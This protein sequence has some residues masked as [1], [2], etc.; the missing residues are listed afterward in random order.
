MK[1]SVITFFLTIFISNFYLSHAEDSTTA[2]NKNFKKEK[3]LIANVQINRTSKDVTVGKVNA[4]MLLINALTGKYDILPTYKRD[5][6]ARY[7]D[8]IKIEANVQN[9]AR[10][11]GIKKLC[12]ISVNRLCNLIRA[13]IIMKLIDTVPLEV[14]SSGFASIHFKKE[15][16]DSSITDPAIFDAIRRAFAIAERDSSM[17][18]NLTV[19]LKI[20]PARTVAVGG[21]AYH[22]NENIYPSWDLFASNVISSY[23]A[24]ETITGAA[25][26]DSST[27]AVDTETRDSIYALYNLYLIENNNQPTTLEITAL[28]NLSIDYYIS[29]NFT[30]VAEGADIELY[31]VDIR[32]R[33]VKIERSVT[34]KLFNDNI[35]EFRALLKD[36]SWRV[37]GLY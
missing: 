14:H 20:I 8:S 16:I 11:L 2:F 3:I 29:G 32:H 22:N 6:V 17:F 7:L 23:D 33:Q 25:I 21:L 9:I 28:Q 15:G 5:S 13:D 27:V 31:L 1:I 35:D 12:F 10:N 30:R 26:L 34:G 4:S 36:L 37:L 24:V 18:M 19:N